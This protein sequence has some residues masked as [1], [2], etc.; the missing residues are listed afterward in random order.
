[1][2][3]QVE[4]LTAGSLLFAA[5]LALVM[6]TGLAQLSLSLAFGIGLSLAIL[7]IAAASNELALYLLIF[8]MLLGPEVV[9]GE[10]RPEGMLGRQLTFRLD[11][12][13][14]AVVGLAWLG[15]TALHKELGLL[16]RRESQDA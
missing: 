10:L 9:V 7:I 13:L 11:D 5:F 15:K 16:L 14:L 1:M 6:G 2:R 3:V 8:S 12:L 4:T